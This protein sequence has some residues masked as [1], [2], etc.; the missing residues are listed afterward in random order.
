[1]KNK[2]RTPRHFGLTVVDLVL[3]ILV[4]AAIGSTVFDRQIR[5]FLGEEQEI[6][7]EYTFVVQNVTAF[8][9]NRP[10]AGEEV[11]ELDSGLPLGKVD[12]VEEK[13]SIYTNGVEEVEIATLTCRATAPALLGENG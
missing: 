5:S 13:S 1:M 12:S 9:V 8:S 4:L 3:L 2:K 10:T 7:V 6:T 11:F